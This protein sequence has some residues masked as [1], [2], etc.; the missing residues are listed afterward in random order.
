MPLLEVEDLRV[1]FGP[2]S[3]PLIAVDGLDLAI[4]AGEV[5]GCVGES[6]SGKSV[7][8]LAVMGLTDYPAA[9]APGASRSRAAISSRCRR[10]STA[11]S[12]ARR[13]R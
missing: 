7:A 11:I 8:A 5:V 4:E 1:E 12:S 3:A 13:S 9:C 6:G 10:R 2:P